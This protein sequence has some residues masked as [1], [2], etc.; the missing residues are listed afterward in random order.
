MT[1]TP[2]NTGRCPQLLDESLRK[3]AGSP[4][5]VCMDHWMSY[6]QLDDLSSSLGAWLQG[7]GLEPGARVA[8]MLPNI[9]QFAGHHGRRPA[10]R[11]HLRERQPAVHGPRAGAPAQG[12]RGHRH[13]H[14]REL[15]QHSGRGD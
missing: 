5:S 7:Q 10:G 13:R 2:T 6:G 12:L 8:I 11:L 15:R 4:F 3:H 9:P 1:S 14:P